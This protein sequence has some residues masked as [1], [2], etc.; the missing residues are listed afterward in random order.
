MTFLKEGPDIKD[1]GESQV[2]RRTA[3]RSTSTVVLAAAIGTL[4][5]GATAIVIAKTRKQRASADAPE[6][7]SSLNAS[8]RAYLDAGRA[9]TLDE[10]TVGKLISDLDAAQAYSYDANSAVGFTTELWEALVNL[11]VD[12]TQK[13]ADAYSIELED[14]QPE[15]SDTVTDMRRLSSV[16]NGGSLLMRHRCALGAP[17]VD[18]RGTARLTG[19]LPSTRS[20]AA[21]AVSSA[22]GS[23]CRYLPVVATEPWPRRSFTTWRSAPPASSQD[24]CEWRRSWSRGRGLSFAA[25]QAGIQTWWRNQSRGMCPSVSRTRGWRGE[26]SPDAR[27]VAG[28]GDSDAAVGAAALANRVRRERSMSVLAARIVWLS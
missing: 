27:R 11:V 25:E 7:V 4:A 10:G 20:S 23:V 5:V 18:E 13:L 16:S 2:S 17:K 1:G 9:G 24:A 14:L 6:C 12:H 8:L 28:S 3:G 19:L 15:A 21:S 22:V 26:S